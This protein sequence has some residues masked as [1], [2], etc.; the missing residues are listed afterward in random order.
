MFVFSLFKQTYK[1]TWFSK[2]AFRG[3]SEKLF[4]NQE[5]R[6]FFYYFYAD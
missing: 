4:G 5:R 2:K 6:C 3:H 1:N